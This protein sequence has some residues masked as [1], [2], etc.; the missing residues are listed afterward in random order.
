MPVYNGALYI[1]EAI[2]SIIGQTDPDW[3][4]I[5]IDDG[6]R[7]NSLDIANRYASSE[8]RIKVF[9]Q[10][11]HGLA[12]TLNRGIREST[13]KYITVLAQ[14]DIKAPEYITTMVT[15]L[16]QNPQVGAAYCQAQFIDRNSNLLDR[17]FRKI[18]PPKH[19]Y[20]E[21]VKGNFI[22]AVSVIMRR[23]VL[24]IVGM[25]DDEL[26]IEDWGLWLRLARSNQMVGIPRTLVR[27][28]VHADSISANQEYM[29]EASLLLL[30]KYFGKLE[31]DPEGWPFERR[32]AYAGHYHRAA[33]SQLFRGEEDQ[34]REF[35]YR[36]I[37]VCPQWIENFEAFYELANGFMTRTLPHDQHSANFGE[38]AERLI[39]FMN[40]VFDSPSTLDAVRGRRSLAYANTYY[41]LGLLSYEQGQYQWARPFLFKALSFSPHMWVNDKVL[42]TLGKTFIPRG[43]PIRKLFQPS[44]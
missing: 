2:E 6:S 16:E 44:A 36:S 42:L 43:S 11:N 41:A 4:L 23:S 37:A 1:C 32:L 12:T 21:L 10:E 20:Q 24:D 40:S 9:N 7:D 25:F 27:Y 18:V 33:L 8:P 28:R 15:V 19:L 31:G 38:V 30:E 35:F 17:G 14:D 13:G 39:H 26:K 22:C 3:E 34:A 5:V 29:Q